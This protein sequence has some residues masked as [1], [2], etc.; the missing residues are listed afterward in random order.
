MDVE[1]SRFAE[2]I[3]TCGFCRKTALIGVVGLHAV[4][5]VEVAPH[6]EGTIRLRDTGGQLPLAQRLTVAQ[7]FGKQGQLHRPHECKGARR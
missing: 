4:P 1:S 7:Q 5:S 2:K 3:Q 6:K